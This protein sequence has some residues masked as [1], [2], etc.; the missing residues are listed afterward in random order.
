L[1]YGSAFVGLEHIGV[2]RRWHPF[3]RGAIY[4]MLMG[5]GVAALMWPMP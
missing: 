4:V 2:I 1:G 5:L 3:V